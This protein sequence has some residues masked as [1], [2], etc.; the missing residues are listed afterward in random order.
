MC[1]QESIFV[2]KYNFHTKENFDPKD[3]Y[4]IECSEIHHNFS[5]NGYLEIMGL[6]YWFFFTKTLTKHSEFSEKMDEK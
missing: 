3:R 6:A 4:E 1:G 5:F 2:K